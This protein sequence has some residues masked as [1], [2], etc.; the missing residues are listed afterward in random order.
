MASL[1]S[2]G[3]EAETL[4]MFCAGSM[5]SRE[6]KFSFR[7]SFLRPSLDKLPTCE[8]S[9]CKDQILWALE[10][11][12]LVDNCC[13]DVQCHLYE[14]WRET[15]RIYRNCESLRYFVNV[16]YGFQVL[17]MK[18]TECSRIVESRLYPQYFKD[19]ILPAILILKCVI[20]NRSWQCI[21]KQLAVLCKSN[22]ICKMFSTHFLP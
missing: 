15:V 20:T 13:F 4:L 18:Q 11:W 5:M 12:Q 21:W 22:F 7:H 6:T 9:Q 8:C 10:S 2:S 16:V 19:Q 17:T 14:L 3:L 1:E